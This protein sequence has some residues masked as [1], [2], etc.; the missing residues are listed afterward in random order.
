VEF[1][2]NSPR[3][4]VV[5]ARYTMGDIEDDTSVLG[6]DRNECQYM[7]CSVGNKRYAG[8]VYAATGS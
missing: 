6:Y 8:D 3:G 4:G 7:Q 2:W 5:D 1:R